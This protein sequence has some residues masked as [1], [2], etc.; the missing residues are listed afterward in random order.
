[1][2]KRYPLDDVKRG[3]LLQRWRPERGYYGGIYRVTRLS[4]LRGKV[5]VHMGPVYE[6]SRVPWATSYY[7]TRLQTE[8][9]YVSA[10]AVEARYTDRKMRQLVR[11]NRIGDL[12]TLKL[13]LVR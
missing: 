4:K 2:R 3:D 6:G 11:K 5:V 1:M 7:R 8:W 13:D 9:R 12:G 10:K